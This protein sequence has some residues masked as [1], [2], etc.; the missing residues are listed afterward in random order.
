[1]TA[2]RIVLPEPDPQLRED[3]VHEPRELKPLWTLIGAFS[4]AMTDLGRKRLDPNC[5]QKNNSKIEIYVMDVKRHASNGGSWETRRDVFLASEEE[6]LELR[7]H[8][9]QL[10]FLA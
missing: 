1:M 9:P 10:N 5:A 2:H 8:A 6:N 7:W 4:S 3:T